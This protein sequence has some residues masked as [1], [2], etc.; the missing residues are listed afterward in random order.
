MDELER[1]LAKRYW[2]PYCLRTSIAQPERIVVKNGFRKALMSSNTPRAREAALLRAIRAVAPEGAGEKVII[3]KDVT[4]RR[5]KDGANLGSSYILFLGDFEGGALVF[6]D[7][8]RFEAKREW[9]EFDGQVPHWNEPHTGTKYSVV[10][11]RSSVAPC[12]TKA[13]RIMRR[14]VVS[15]GQNP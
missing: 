11:Y 6:D 14:R 4:C 5:H 3:N 7:G 2:Q 12:D 10:L 13:G 8:T 15:E 9:F 1:L